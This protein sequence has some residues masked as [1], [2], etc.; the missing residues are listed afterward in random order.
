MII[1]KDW[2]YE[3]VDLPDINSEEDIDA[4]IEAAKKVFPVVKKKPNR[5]DLNQEFNSSNQK[6][7][8]ENEQIR[9]CI[10]GFGG[11]SG[12][13]YFYYHFCWIQNVE[14]GIIR[15]EFR[16]LDAVWFRLLDDCSPGE[17]MEGQ[18]LI[19]LKRRRSGFSWKAACDV[20]H[21]SLFKVGASVGMT[22]KSERDSRK[23][24][25]KVQFIFDRLPDFLK[26]P[27]GGG[28]S[29]DY[30]RFGRKSKDSYGNKKISGTNSELYC[31][32]PTDSCFEGDMLSR[33]ILDEAGKIK[34]LLTIWALSEDC[35]MQETKRLGVPVVFGTAGEQGEGASGDGQ[36]QMWMNNKAYMLTRFLCPGWAGLICDKNGNDNIEEAVR[37]IMKQRKRLLDSGSTTYWDYVQKYPLTAKEALLIKGRTGIGNSKKIKEREYEL[38]KN[39]ANYVEGRFR[40]GKDNEKEVVFEP[41]SIFDSS[42][43]CRIYAHPDNIMRY[44]AGCD[45]ADHD[46][47]ND[48]SSDLS[49]YIMNKQRGALP[50]SIVFSYTDRPEKV[51]DYYEQSLMAL[52]Y[53]HGT[54]VLIENNRNGMIKYFENNEYIHL[55]KAEPRARNS[56]NL[57]V[58][59]RLG[60]RKTTTSTKEMEGHINHYTDDYCDLIPEIELIKEFSDYGNKNT[61][62]VIAFG[63][64]LF[65]LDDELNTEKT[66]EAVKRAIPRTVLRKVNG[67]LTRV[68][69]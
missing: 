52:I 41:N 60:V 30:M 56:L 15:P 23:L 47:V 65:S 51:N 24:F 34:N 44:A 32:P 4:Y 38:E 66:E 69:K 64:C 5:V 28:Q 22:S 67:V 54:Q 36:R 8:W 10:Y 11:I 16:V 62:R 9:R 45:P 13:M 29:R 57:K 40:W 42:G 59:N 33:M 20:I 2:K 1:D 7:S 53:Y 63:W 17:R 14:E 35:L 6:L 58:K 55:L 19:C 46:Y 61:D 27:M 50:P 68:K 3:Y 39:P 43:K 21:E 48:G 37:E 26:M 31:V 25:K 18:G 12:K 49:M